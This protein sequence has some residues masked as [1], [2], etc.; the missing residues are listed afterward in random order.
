MTPPLIH[1]LSPGI[2][3]GAVIGAVLVVT[4]LGLASYYVVYKR[5]VKPKQATAFSKV[6][7]GASNTEDTLQHHHI[8]AQAT[9][10]VRIKTFLL[11][12]A[13]PIA[14]AQSDIKYSGITALLP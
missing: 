1:R 14:L 7:D 2:I 4:A 10:S 6:G 5:L 13:G 8:A 3:A 9:D 12:G 11:L